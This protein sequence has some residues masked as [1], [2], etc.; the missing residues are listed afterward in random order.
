[1]LGAQFVQRFGDHLGADERSGGGDQ[2]RRVRQAELFGGDHAAEV[3]LVADHDVRPPVGAQRQHPLGPVPGDPPGEAL[4]QVAVFALGVQ[5]KQRHPADRIL[6]GGAGA[7]EREP[8]LLH[9]LGHRLPPDDRDGVA[10]RDTGS[11]D[12]NHRLEVAVAADEGEEGAHRA[13]LA[14]RSPGLTS[15]VPARHRAPHHARG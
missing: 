6:V 2:H 13:N 7:D 11:G 10:G 12:R 8:G 5:R 14:M 4:P 1:V 3:D 15:I 9:Q